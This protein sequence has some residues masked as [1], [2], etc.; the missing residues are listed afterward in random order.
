MSPR[1]LAGRS[2]AEPIHRHRQRPTA[3]KSARPSAVPSALKGWPTGH[4]ARSRY[5]ALA[6]LVAKCA[7]PASPGSGKREV[8][9]P[10]SL[11]LTRRCR[12]GRARVRN[13]RPSDAPGTGRA[14]RRRQAKPRVNHHEANR[15]ESGDHGLALERSGSPS[16]F[17]LIAALSAAR[18]LGFS[19]PSA[20]AKKSR[21]RPGRADRRRGKPGSYPL[22]HALGRRPSRCDLGD[23]RGCDWPLAGSPHQPSAAL[24][25]GSGKARL[26]T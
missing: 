15:A 20:Q 1:R 4:A 23:L 7:T 6:A 12:G 3:Q 14:S 26:W 19:A 8:G 17:N 9:A 5:V 2:S 25:I 21:P 10:A 22:R 24:A 16:S 11:R 13:F 18:P